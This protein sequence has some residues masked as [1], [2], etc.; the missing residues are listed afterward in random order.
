MTYMA[1]LG[2]DKVLREAFKKGT[3]ILGICLG[4]QIVLEKSEEGDEDCLGLVSGKT[5]RF[6]LKDKRLKIPHIGWNE[7]RAAREHPVLEGLQPGDE[8]YFDHA[9]YPQPSRKEDI[10]AITDYGID[11]CSA[12]GYKNLFAVQFHPEKSG[13]PGLRL[14]ECFAK[15]EGKI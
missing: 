4:A 9:F 3:P 2:L 11:F 13:R 7:V 6:T 1:D 15:W 5:V 10:Y 8:F 14:L 12:L